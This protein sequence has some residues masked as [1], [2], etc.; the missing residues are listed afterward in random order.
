MVRK[1]WTLEE[2]N[3]L[4]EGYEKFKHS[5]QL[6]RDIF[7]NYITIL[8]R[9]SG[10]T[11][12]KDKMKN[13]KKREASSIDST[14]ISSTTSTPITRNVKPKIYSDSS[15]DV[16]TES[17]SELKESKTA[18]WTLEQDEILKTA[19]S[20]HHSN[21]SDIYKEF[22]PLLLD[23]DKKSYRSRILSFQLSQ[24]KLY[25]KV[26]DRI[27]KPIPSKE[28]FLDKSNF[29]RRLFTNNLVFVCSCGFAHN[30]NKL[31]SQ[32]LECKEKDTDSVTCAVSLENKLLLIQKQFDWFVI[33]ILINDFRNVKSTHFISKFQKNTLL[34]PD[35]LFFKDISLDSLRV[36]VT[37]GKSS[38]DTILNSHV[39]SID[40]SPI[41]NENYIKVYNGFKLVNSESST[42]IQSSHVHNLNQDHFHNS[43]G[44]ICTYVNVLDNDFCFISTNS[45]TCRPLCNTRR[46]LNSLK[47]LEPS[48]GIT[49]KISTHVRL[50]NPVTRFQNSH[51]NPIWT[52]EFTVLVLERN[53]DISLSTIINYK[54]ILKK[55]WKH[56]II[57]HIDSPNLVFSKI[58]SLSQSKYSQKSM[59]IVI[60]VII[61]HLTDK[62]LITLFFNNGIFLR[63]SYQQL[64]FSL[65]QDIQKNSQIMNLREFNN[66]TSVDNIK[67]AVLKMESLNYTTLYDFQKIVWFKMQ[68]FQASTRNEARLIKVAN[69][70]VSQDN[71]ID[72]QSNKFVYNSFKT[73]ATMSTMVFDINPLILDDVLKLA[74]GRIRDKRDFLFANTKGKPFKSSQ[75][76]TFIINS[77]LKFLP[78]RIGSQQLRKILVSHFRNHELTIAQKKS[79]ADSMLHSV[80]TNERYRRIIPSEFC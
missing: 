16:S 3:A 29:K 38:I 26:E 49:Q 41:H 75:F 2:T 4:I 54:T 45:C 36:S 31:I 59:L 15:N 23:H 48:S 27:S 78:A 74:H 35:D 55:L 43:A 76:S 9:H 56:D 39:D 21:W 63:F 62:E 66:W 24:M 32:N 20:K 18:I 60:S 30:H 42:S 79:L 68:L 22:G 33:I 72:L 80:G 51:P 19:Y 69:Y 14:E 67:N 46:I 5:K 11:D 70:S 50:F 57:Q 28:N 53:S 1:I 12:L 37:L 58:Q 47:N 25:G 6:W 13:I 10:P 8:G 65:D 52:P 73:S 34:K 61:S 77:M 64:L 71:Y 7:E 44:I 40:I 17:L